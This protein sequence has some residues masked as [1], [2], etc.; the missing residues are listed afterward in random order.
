M[1]W[2]QLLCHYRGE[3][4]GKRPLPGRAEASDRLSKKPKLLSG[5]TN[6]LLLKI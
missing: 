5:T 6:R 4:R 2:E 3:S 1:I